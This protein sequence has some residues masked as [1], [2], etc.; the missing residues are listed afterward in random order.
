RS[1][2]DLVARPRARSRARRALR[3]ACAGAREGCSDMTR[4]RLLLT[5]GACV[6]F[7]VSC[8]FMRGGL[9]SSEQFGDAS[10]YAADAH[11]MLH[12]Q[13]PYRDFFFE[14]PPGALVVFLLPALVSVAHY[15]VL[16]KV[17]M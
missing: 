14:Y 4:Q 5:I 15:A 17:L 8:T 7:V 12:G 2:S 13:V 10:L 1:P 16:F 11:R 9:A 3:D 6:L